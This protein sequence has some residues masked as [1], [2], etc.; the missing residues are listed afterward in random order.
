MINVYRLWKARDLW[1]FMMFKI[2]KNTKTFA[3]NL[4]LGKSCGG[5]GGVALVITIGRERERKRARHREAYTCCTL[6]S[7]RVWVR[8][9]ASVCLSVCVRGRDN[10]ETNGGSLGPVV[11]QCRQIADANALTIP[12]EKSSLTTGQDR[13]QPINLVLF[14]TSSVERGGGEC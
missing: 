8:V 12:V 10:R 1:R 3:K 4:W 13:W 14:A 5:E 2:K 6:V 11:N 7:V 9:R